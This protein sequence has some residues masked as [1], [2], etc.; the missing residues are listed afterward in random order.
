MATTCQFARKATSR[1]S[2]LDPALKEF[3]DA[4]VIPALV[5][6]YI[7]EDGVQN[8]L[9]TVPND[10]THFVSKTSIFAKEVL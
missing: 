9:A 2:L 10:V 1:D 5:K 6:A 8:S 4:V 7:R 3:L